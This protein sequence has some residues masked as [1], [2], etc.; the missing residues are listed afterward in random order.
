[1]LKTSSP[2][3][4]ANRSSRK[5]R[6]GQLAEANGSCCWVS[7]GLNQSLWNPLIKIT[8]TRFVCKLIAKSSIVSNPCQLLN[9]I[10]TGGANF[11]LVHFRHEYLRNARTHSFK[12]PWLYPLICSEGSQ[13]IFHSFWMQICEKFAPQKIEF[14]RGQNWPPPRSCRP[15]PD[16][17]CAVAGDCHLFFTQNMSSGP[18]GVN[19]VL[20]HWQSYGLENH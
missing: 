20:L 11:V 13:T 8:L 6:M 4:N 10:R 9:P 12:L 2:R 17:W 14:C 18:G 19:C 1:M 15:D 16:F 3:T 5:I 7:T